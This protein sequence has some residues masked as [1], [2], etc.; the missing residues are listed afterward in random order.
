[1]HSRGE[2][3]GVS[4]AMHVHMSKTIPN[5][6]LVAELETTLN[7]HSTTLLQTDRC[8]PPSL[9]R[10]GRIDV[11]YFTAHYSR[12]THGRTRPWLY[13]MP[14]HAQHKP[15]K[16]ACGGRVPWNSLW[17]CCPVYCYALALFFYHLIEVGHLP[18]SAPTY[19]SVS[20]P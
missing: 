20:V 16:C 18:W 6:T 19:E 2:A 12:L 14:G 11:N 15:F 10:N 1:M 13:C 9:L 3:I 5:G 7:L 4:V 8:L 17:K